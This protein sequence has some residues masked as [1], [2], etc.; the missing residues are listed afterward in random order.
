MIEAVTQADK[1]LYNYTHCP[2]VILKSR[3]L[4]F[5][6]YTG[7]NDPKESKV[8][9]F[10]LWTSG[11]FDL[12]KYDMQTL[13]SWLSAALKANTRI[14]CFAMDTP[15]L[16]GDH[17]SDIFSRGW[18]KPRMWAQYAGSH[19]G[20]CLVFDRQR[21]DEQIRKQFQPTHF[22]V[23]GQ[24]EYVNRAVIQNFSDT[25]YTINIDH[26]EN[27]GPQ[28]Y[29]PWHLRSHFTR[30]FFEKMTDW[31]AESEF[32]WIVISGS[33][34]DLYLDLENALVGVVF[35][36]ETPDLAISDMI[37]ITKD[38]R[39]RYT[40]LKWKNCSPWYDY[41]NVRYLGLNV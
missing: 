7:T 33:T 41:Q 4:R 21:L 37:K 31:T 9:H 32:R 29:P 35:G 17:L 25:A 11:R 28:K 19:K 20:A 8:W 12:G 1:Y 30:F 39:L 40:G 34:N 24:V 3:K 6:K 15:P 18:C 13:G 14:A 2:E 22:V 10:N 16:S 36:E 27:V 23:S 38:M 5:G 26:L